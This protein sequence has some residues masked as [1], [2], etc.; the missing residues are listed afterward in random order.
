MTT[1]KPFLLLLT[2]AFLGKRN[3]DA[4]TKR[5]SIS[6]R[7]VEKDGTSVDTYV[8][9][10]LFSPSRHATPPGSPRPLGWPMVPRAQVHGP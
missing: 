3:S 7:T 2:R 8:E 5:G 4:S 10:S 1:M 6:F 9:L